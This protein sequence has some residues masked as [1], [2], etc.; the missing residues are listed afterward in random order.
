QP[1]ERNNYLSLAFKSSLIFG[2]P[3]ESVTESAT[4]HSVL[5]FAIT[6][7]SFLIAPGRGRRRSFARRPARDATTGRGPTRKGASQSCGRVSRGPLSGLSWACRVLGL[8]CPGPVVDRSVPRR[9]LFGQL[10]DRGGRAA[11]TLAA[12][13]GVDREVCHECRGDVRN[14]RKLGE[15][16]RT[17][18]GPRPRVRVRRSGNHR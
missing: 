3:G 14:P 16:D 13:R 7:T 4:T 1:A 2:E 9:L 5:K 18:A 11:R 10:P 17:R 15:R 8:S 6:S 12:G